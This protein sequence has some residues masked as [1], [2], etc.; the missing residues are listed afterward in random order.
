MCLSGTGRVVWIA[1]AS[2][3]QIATPSSNLAVQ[4]FAECRYSVPSK[5]T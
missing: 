2:S 1:E 4:S 5:S 3:I